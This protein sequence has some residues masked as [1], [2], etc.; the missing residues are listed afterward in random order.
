MIEEFNLTSERQRMAGDL[1]DTLSQGLAGVIMQLEAVNANINNN[2]TK[3]AQEIFKKAMEHA[4]RTLADSR[5]II[6]D[7]G[8]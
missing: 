7:L 5:L 6:D 1:Q 8:R 4:R 3:R 2:N